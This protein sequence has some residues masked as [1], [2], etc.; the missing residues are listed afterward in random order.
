SEQAKE[1]FNVQTPTSPAT[2]SSTMNVQDED[3]EVAGQVKI[4]E[5]LR[6][7]REEITSMSGAA[8]RKFLKNLYLP[9]DGTIEEVRQRLTDLMFPQVE[10]Q[11]EQEQDDEDSA[12]G[13][14]D[15]SETIDEA[16]NENDEFQETIQQE[17]SSSLVDIEDAEGWLQAIWQEEG[18]QMEEE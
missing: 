3:G 4:P 14:E 1:Q 2:D 9:T 16:T 5:E 15:E 8:M 13:D 18:Q 17:G 6:L 10:T 7:S 12:N 11:Q